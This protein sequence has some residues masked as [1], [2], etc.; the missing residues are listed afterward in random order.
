MT[1]NCEHTRLSNS[2]ITH[3]IRDGL[4][5]PPIPRR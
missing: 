3:D 2:S 4:P 1:D 5:L